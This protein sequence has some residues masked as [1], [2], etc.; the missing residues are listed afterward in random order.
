M[1]SKRRAAK[2]SFGGAQAPLFTGKG[3]GVAAPP[4]KQTSAKGG[5][6]LSDPKAKTGDRVK[7]NV[8]RKVAK[9][10]AAQ[11]RKS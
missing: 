9:R 11:T 3:G 1:P 4:G 5:Y 8:V 6:L 2:R 7:P 10:R